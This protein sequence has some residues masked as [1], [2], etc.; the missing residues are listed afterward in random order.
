MTNAAR[1]PSDVQVAI[2]GA[3]PAGL[4]TAAALRAKGVTGVVFE[5]ADSVATSW[6]GHYDRLHLHTVRWLSN[7][8]GMAIPRSEGRWV[9]R[10][11]VVRYLE[12]YAAHHWIEV[13]TGVTV[14]KV[15]RAGGRW[16]LRSAQGDVRADAVVVATG[17]NHTP[18]M[19]DVPGIDGFTGELLHAKSYR[20]GA[21]Y[22]SKD[23]LVVGPG[24]TGAEIAVDLAEHGASRV[25]LSIRSAPYIL[26]R[27][28]G[29]IP[30]QLTGVLMRRI[31]APIADVVAEPVRKLSIPNLEHKGLPDPGRGVYTRAAAG[32]V[33]ILDVGLLDAIESDKV[34]PVAGLAGFDGD[35]VLLSD[36]SAID[37]DVVIVAAG[38]QRGLQQLVGHLDVLGAN[39]RPVVHGPKTRGGAPGLH[40]IG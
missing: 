32:R 27:A 14:D 8:P 4:A 1:S 17:Y 26:R 34:E 33:P 21:P 24:N 36:E 22:A 12:D 35:K 37:P 19:P 39:G 13:R 2:I 18:V 3:G 5:R 16:L 31:P 38:Y 11:G 9:S 23:V 20:N 30:A 25:R 28:P 10:D 15:E 7:L 6:R 29:G 40:F